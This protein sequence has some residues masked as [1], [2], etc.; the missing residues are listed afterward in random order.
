MDSFYSKDAITTHKMN[1]DTRHIDE[2]AAGMGGAAETTF[3]KPMV[4][5]M[6][7]NSD[8]APTQ[9]SNVAQQRYGS[10]LRQQTGAENK[11]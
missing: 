6:D 4:Q 11:G 3:G 8:P 5:I 7:L 1:L 10:R 2:T 9:M